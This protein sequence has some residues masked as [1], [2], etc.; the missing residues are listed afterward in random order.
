M[1]LLA[2]FIVKVVLFIRS[3]DCPFY[4]TSPPLLWIAIFMSTND[5]FFF[6]LGDTLQCTRGVIVVGK[7]V[8]SDRVVKVEAHED[9]EWHYEREEI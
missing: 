6:F 1:L 4:C 5:S 2:Q 8:I 7:R 3:M 9:E